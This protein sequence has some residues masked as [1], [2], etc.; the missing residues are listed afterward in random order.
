MIETSGTDDDDDVSVGLSTV[1]DAFFSAFSQSAK[2]SGI[3]TNSVSLLDVIVASPP[4]TDLEALIVSCLGSVAPL[5]IW[6]TWR[7]HSEPSRVEHKYVL[8]PSRSFIFACSH[9]SLFGFL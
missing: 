6:S 9:K 2:T 7:L 4:S 5:A 1:F 3:E 8:C